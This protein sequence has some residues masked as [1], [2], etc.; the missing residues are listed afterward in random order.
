MGPLSVSPSWVGRSLRFAAAAVFACWPVVAAERANGWTLEEIFDAPRVIEVA[1]APGGADVA[2]TVQRAVRQGEALQWERRLWRSGTTGSEPV[3]LTRVGGSAFDPSFSPD[4]SRLA[5]R[6]D[7]GGT[8]QVWVLPVDGGEAWQV[9][10]APAGVEAYRWAGSG[11]ALIYVAARHDGKPPAAEAAAG[12]GPVLVGEDEPPHRL[13]RVEL[14]PERGVRGDVQEIDTGEGHVAARRALSFGYLVSGFDV[15][16]DGGRIVFTHTPRAH[17]DDWPLAD[18][19]VI[20]L[21]SGRVRPLVTTSRAEGSPLFSPDG[22]WIA[23]TASGDPPRPP[24]ASR[25]YVVPATGGEPRALASTADERPRLV[26]WSADGSQLYVTEVR[27]TVT[28]LSAL[29]V[30]GSPPR[31]LDSGHRVLEG[32]VLDSTRTKIGFL[33]ESPTEPPEAFVTDAERFAPLQVSEVGGKLPNR[34]VSETE[35]IRWKAPDGRQIEGLLTYPVGY[36]SDRRAP[37]LLVVHG[38]PTG[39]FLQRFPAAPSPYPLATFATRGF[40][41][42]QPNP[43][44]STGYGREF[45]F[46]NLGD[47]GGMDYRDLMAGVDHVVQQGVADPERLGVMGWSYGGYM[48]GWIVSQT[49]RF[50]AASSGAGISNLASFAG[51]SD[52]LGFVP[53]YFDGLPWESAQIYVERSPLFQLAGATT[54][55]LIQH[56]G[57]DPRVPL[58]QS[59]ELYHGLK[60]LGVKTEMVIYPGQGHGI[61]DPQLLLDA[62]RRNLEW[63]EH[64]LLDGS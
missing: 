1:V 30:D 51:T 44:G 32:A 37:L 33:A 60:R 50:K 28:R 13:F 14:S 23:Y 4:G 12:E 3:A 56:G 27:G 25:V 8:D 31:D 38:G 11:E 63:F 57:D 20:D 64:H 35:L 52:L 15:S 54:P 34:P 17:T 29:P 62:A 55:T 48:T 41:I 9:T 36:R 42:L 18:V 61:S 10:E 45:R 19:S 43:R 59:F 7:R 39:A 6:S 24:V 46:A 58:S 2:F 53:G 21:E 40:A 47:W 26:G 22:R 5:F 49:G 16:P